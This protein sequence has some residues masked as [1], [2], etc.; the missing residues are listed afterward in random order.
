[1]SKKVRLLTGLFLIALPF[2]L[3][4]M[5]VNYNVHE[6]KLGVK[7]MTGQQLT[8]EEMKSASI[9]KAYN[10][11]NQSTR[12]EDISSFLNKKSKNI[13]DNF[14]SWFYPY[15][16]VSI[17]YRGNGKPGVFVKIVSFKTPYTT[18][19][20]EEEL[21]SV[22][23]CNSIEEIS[24]ILGEAAI[25]GKTYDKQG[26]VSDSS[27]EWG[28]KTSL[29]KEIVDNLEKLYGEYVRFP[30]RYS[31]PYNFLKS[32]SMERKLR[33]RVS[34][35]ADNTIESFSIDEYKNRH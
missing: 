33:L 19:L 34:I 27:Y 10:Q 26:A 3:L 11:I 23:E 35:N 4:L 32:I 25:L 15:G 21:Y 7:A 1:M 12:V 16:Y 18:K 28:I 22:F 2:F 17:W 14:E 13:L 6:F 24:G 20:A 5:D 9:Y 29:S 31:S 8:L 30:D